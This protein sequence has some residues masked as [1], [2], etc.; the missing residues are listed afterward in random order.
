LCDLAHVLSPQAYKFLGYLREQPGVRFAGYVSD[1]IKYLSDKYGVSYST[2]KRLMAELTTTKVPG[3]DHAFV[4]IW[5]DHGSRRFYPVNQWGECMVPRELADGGL[6]IEPCED[7]ACDPAAVPA[8]YEAPHAKIRDER[9]NVNVTSLE[10]KMPETPLVSQVDLP[11]LADQASNAA[12]S[13]VSPAS[14][15]AIELAADPNADLKAMSDEQLDRLVAELKASRDRREARNFRLWQAQAILRERR[16]PSGMRPL[17][18]DQGPTAEP[19][20]EAKSQSTRVPGRLQFG[21]VVGRA[22]NATGPEPLEALAIR[23]AEDLRDPSMGM[24]R[25]VAKGLRSGIVKPKTVVKAYE[26]ARKSGVDNPGANFVW[27]VD[28]RNPG[29]REWRKGQS[30]AKSRDRSPRR[31]AVT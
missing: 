11:F 25:M 26:Q 8:H 2:G 10:P 7:Q 22:L 28:D 4:G 9:E 15:Q 29:F 18:S 24:F 1:P 30:A 13:L 5:E 20:P 27:Q 19:E 23:L 17:P 16:A 6:K 21:T 3:Y 12:A 14:D 31:R